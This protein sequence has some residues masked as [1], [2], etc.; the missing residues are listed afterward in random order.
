MSG[1]RKRTYTSEEH[2]RSGEPATGAASDGAASDGAARDG[3]ARDGG[4]MTAGD[5]GN[6][7]LY[8]HPNENFLSLANNTRV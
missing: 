7:P 5:R 2:F 8:L 6:R 1:N 3:A 4:G